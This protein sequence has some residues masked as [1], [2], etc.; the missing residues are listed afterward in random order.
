MMEV[1]EARN[2]AK[3]YSSVPALA[4]V[5][6]KIHLGEVVGLVGHNGAGKSTLL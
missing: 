6:I 3:Y 2:I 1:F 5:S 4:G